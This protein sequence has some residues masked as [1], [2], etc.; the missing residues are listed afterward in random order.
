VFDERQV[1]SNV[2]L[3]EAAA[4]ECGRV[5]VRRTVQQVAHLRGSPLPEVH[6]SIR[7]LGNWSDVA[8]LIEA[9]QILIRESFEDR[10]R[11]NPATLDRA[12]RVLREVQNLFGIRHVALS[13]TLIPNP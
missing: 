9:E 8:V 13:P 7:V 6:E 4:E 12:E 3:R 2:C 5:P 1:L 10:V 11:D